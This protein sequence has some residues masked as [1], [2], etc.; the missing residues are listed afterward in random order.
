M[1]DETNSGPNGQQIIGNW[2]AADINTQTVTIILNACNWP[3]FYVSLRNKSLDSI[4]LRAGCL[5][6]W[7]LRCRTKP[8]RHN[9]PCSKLWCRGKKVGGRF[10]V[11]MIWDMRQCFSSET[12]DVWFCFLFLSLSWG[13]FDIIGIKYN[14][15]VHASVCMTWH[16]G[17]FLGMILRSCIQAH[18]SLYSRLISLLALAD[19]LAVAYSLRKWRSS[20]IKLYPIRQ[21]GH[22][23]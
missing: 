3:S 23:A 14:A 6:P 17:T 4:L 12:L 11:F 18:G 1:P 13:T 9:T 22:V 16:G 2:C 7:T 15:S 10:V 19:I 20:F 8:L 21:V 5:D